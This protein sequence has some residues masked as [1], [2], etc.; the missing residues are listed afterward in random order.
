[1]KKRIVVLLFLDALFGGFLLFG[2][3]LSVEKIAN[4]A[5]GVPLTALLALSAASTSM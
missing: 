1:M 2:Q 4:S 3:T 5:N